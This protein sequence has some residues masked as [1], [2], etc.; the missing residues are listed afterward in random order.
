M[1]ISGAYG[2]A[3]YSI[4]ADKEKSIKELSSGKKLNS[5]SDNV[6][7]LG[8]S[9]KL[10]AQ[11]KEFATTIKNYQTQMSSYQVGDSA[12]GQITDNLN[13]LKE[14]VVQYDNGTLS[15]SDKNIIKEQANQILKDIDNTAKSTEFN[16]KKVI[17]D[18]SSN[19]LGISKE[20]LFSEGFLKKVDSAL[21]KITDKRSEF[22]S[23]V[24]QLQNEVA[25]TRVA[26]ENSVAANSKIE[27]TDMLAS[28]LN[29][30]KSQI[31]EQSNLAVTTQA[32][33]SQRRIMDILKD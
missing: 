19:N 11:S 13:K 30:T 8:I 10:E 6:V 7:G 23:K 25:K 16:S 18:F 4:L 21:Q 2:G 20:S 12:L 31:A 17:E 15:D 22:G 33:L 5:A 29:N 27:D 3:L 9:N 32:N 14:L 1:K 24:N 26:Y 28:M